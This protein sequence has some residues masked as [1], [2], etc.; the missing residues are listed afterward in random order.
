M[1]IFRKI[2]FQGTFFHQHHGKG[3]RNPII[4]II[5]RVPLEDTEIAFKEYLNLKQL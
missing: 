4:T 5:Q 1:V 2:A 3:L